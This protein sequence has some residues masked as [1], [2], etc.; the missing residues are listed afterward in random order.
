MPALAI[1]ARIATWVLAYKSWSCSACIAHSE[2]C[3]LRKVA[4]AKMGL[5]RGRLHP[6]YSHGFVCTIRSRVLALCHSFLH[7]LSIYKFKV[8]PS[9]GDVEAMEG[10]AI[11]YT[12][13]AGV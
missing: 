6:A 7:L 5:C 13:L 12:M 4:T 3:S 1:C 2:H 8:A 10:V 11:K 9:A